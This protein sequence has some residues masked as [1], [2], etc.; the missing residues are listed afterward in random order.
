MDKI[1]ATPMYKCAVCGEVYDSIAQRMNCEQTCLKKK[2]EEE[3]KAA[4]AKK[5]AERKADFEEASS[6][7]DNALRLVNKCVEK[8]GTFKYD[9][10]LLNNLETL[11]VDFL[12][13]KLLHY[14]MF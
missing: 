3:R 10:E 14:F 5:N 1:C 11:K 12:P 8:H 2:E 4:E 6:A 9:G 7:I 13:S